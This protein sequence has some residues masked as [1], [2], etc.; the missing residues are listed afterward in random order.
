MPN[1]TLIVALLLVAVIV[2][3]VIGALLHRR[4]AG[5]DG[6]MPYS[7]LRRKL[8]SAMGDENATVGPVP[9][10]PEGLDTRLPAE[11]AEV[12]RSAD[13]DSDKA[14]KV[15]MDVD[16]SINKELD[17]IDRS[18][19]W[20]ELLSEP[21]RVFYAVYWLEAEVNNGGFDQYY[22]NSPSDAA[23]QVPGML[24]E[25][26]MND[27]AELVERANAVFPKGPPRSREARLA[28]M[29]KLGDAASGKWGEI[30]DEFF[31]RNYTCHGPLLDYVRR[32][33]QQFFRV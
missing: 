26:G 15:L 11:D 12:L 16:T 31:D 14:L 33:E 20:L 1:I 21:R 28:Q 23:S 29:E 30:D 4:F 22:I 18:E 6:P 25:I 24:R 9:P 32:N 27:L 8:F 13:N 2:M 3:A 17:A 19:L 5:G 10:R 7:A